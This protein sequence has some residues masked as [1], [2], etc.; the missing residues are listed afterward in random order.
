MTGHFQ[1]NPGHLSIL[2]ESGSY[3]NDLFQQAVTL[4]TLGVQVLACFVGC[5]PSDGPISRAFQVILVYMV[6]LGP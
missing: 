5:G 3:V 2:E 6:S 1:L 4:L